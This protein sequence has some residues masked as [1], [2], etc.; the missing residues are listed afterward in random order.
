MDLCVTIT[1]YR[2]QI[3]IQV[4]MSTS[5]SIRMVPQNLQETE[6]G[7]SFTI[8]QRFLKLD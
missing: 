8:C 2:W 6:Q 3:D 4:A 5:G 7:L 1:A